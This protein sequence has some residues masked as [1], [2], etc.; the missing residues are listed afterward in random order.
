MAN[1][2]FGPPAPTLDPPD[3]RT[4][5]I[6][7]SGGDGGIL[8]RRHRGRHSAGKGSAPSG[9]IRRSS[10]M[11]GPA[12]RLAAWF[13]G[14]G[15]GEV[16][17]RSQGS[18]LAGGA[19]EESTTR[20]SPP[21]FYICA[22]FSSEHAFDDAS[23]HLFRVIVVTDARSFGIG[24]SMVAVLSDFFCLLPVDFHPDCEGAEK[25][26]RTSHKAMAED[27]YPLQFQN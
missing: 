13:R 18:L 3:S 9:A 16:R 23:P 22:S 4:K 25:K 12:A 10:A 1:I 5:S 27:P 17:G 6:P 26:I 20:G 14:G 24:C 19:A 11:R 21:A 2:F 7:P 15:A 8:R